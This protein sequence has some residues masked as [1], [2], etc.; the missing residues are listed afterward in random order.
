MHG[1]EVEREDVQ[2]HLVQSP[3]S[4]MRVVGRD[5]TF[6]KALVVMSLTNSLAERNVSVA[7]EVL[8]HEASTYNS[9]KA[10]GSPERV[11]L[12]NRSD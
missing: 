12:Q 6:R 2:V 8:S 9:G 4:E 3:K 10:Y 1:N 5:T 11:H 7:K